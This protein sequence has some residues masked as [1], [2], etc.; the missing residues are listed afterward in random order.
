MT[1]SPLATALMRHVPH[2]AVDPP[3]HAH[4]LDFLVT[5]H[6]APLA[7]H[8]LE[9]AARRL[10]S[11]GIAVLIGLASGKLAEGRRLRHAARRAG[12]GGLRLYRIGE[13]L[14]R[15]MYMVPDTTS[16]LLAHSAATGSPAVKGWLRRIAIRLGVAPREFTGFV[17]VG[18][19]A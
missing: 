6:F 2:L 13:S 12:F 8:R 3:T 4:P 18:T 19:R 10:T 15:P 5:L 1:G 11:G 16:A 14:D 7:P 17:L 9:D